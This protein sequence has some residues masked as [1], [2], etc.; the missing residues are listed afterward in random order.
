MQSIFIEPKK[1]YWFSPPE[2]V[3][4]YEDW[5]IEAI[6]SRDGICDCFGGYSFAMYHVIFGEM[7]SASPLNSLK[8]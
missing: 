3:G 2:E 6:S 5:D 1:L 8:C 7:E 4:S